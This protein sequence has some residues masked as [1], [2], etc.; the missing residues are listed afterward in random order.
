MPV[1]SDSDLFRAAEALAAEIAEESPLQ[2]DQVLSTTDLLRR[3]VVHLGVI[4]ENGVGG[5]GTALSLISQAAAAAGVETDARSVSALRIKQAFDA[6]L[7]A[8]IGAAPGALDTLDELAAALADDASFAATMTS[9]LAGKLAA[10]NNLSDL[11]SAPTARVNLGVPL[12]KLGYI[13]VTSAADIKLDNI[14][15]DSL[16][17]HYIIQG[18]ALP[19]TNNVTFAPVL[20]DA[21]PADVSGGI[22]AGGIMTR[23]DSNSATFDFAQTSIAGSVS[24]TSSGGVAFEMGLTVQSG[25][26]HRFALRS[27]ATQ[28]GGGAGINIQGRHYQGWFVDSTLREGIKFAFSSGNIASGWLSVVGVKK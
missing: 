3:L 4:A 26:Y 18:F 24:N 15:D 9:A 27:Q 13:T 22:A 23:L 10:S 8:W 16:Y 14:F 6:H 25:T 2:P 5:G 20:R 28:N 11:G 17:S 19:A 12:E 21:T 7:A 1:L